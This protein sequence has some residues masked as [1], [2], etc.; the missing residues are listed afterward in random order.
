[1]PN[2]SPSEQSWESALRSSLSTLS[3]DAIQRLHERYGTQTI[4]E[5]VSVHRDRYPD[6]V[7]D[8]LPSRVGSLVESVL[9][10][11]GDE[12]RTYEKGPTHDRE[13]YDKDHGYDKEGFSR[14]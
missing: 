6:V 9:N 7:Q 14:T 11:G 2:N 8:G 10:L 5:V 13:P 12:G 1:M 3:S 4:D